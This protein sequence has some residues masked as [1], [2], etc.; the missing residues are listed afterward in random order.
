[1]QKKKKKKKKWK[2]VSFAWVDAV[3]VCLQSTEQ[4]KW[5]ISNGSFAV[6]FGRKHWKN[7][8]D[9]AFENM[10]TSFSGQMGMNDEGYIANEKL[11][12]EIIRW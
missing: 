7:L 4:K 3:F 2:T 11:T 1:M 12:V 6:N 10:N 8:I 5:N 9:K